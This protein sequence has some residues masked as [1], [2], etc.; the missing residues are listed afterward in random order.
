[1]SSSCHCGVM[2]VLPML[3]N[4]FSGFLYIQID[5][6]NTL[7]GPGV[8]LRMHSYLFPSVSLSGIHWDFNQDNL[9]RNEWLNFIYPIWPVPYFLWF[10]NIVSF[11]MYSL[12]VRQ[13][14]SAGALGAVF[15]VW[16][17]GKSFFHWLGWAFLFILLIWSCYKLCRFSQSQ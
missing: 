12:G 13:V 10:W 17:L 5:G 9:I 7:S 1:M 16:L 3:V 6:L 8:L 2:H 4:D 15:I 14:A 11:V